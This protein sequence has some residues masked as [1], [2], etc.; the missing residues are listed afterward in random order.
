MFS[1][2]PSQSH[3]FQNMIKRFPTVRTS[4]LLLNLPTLALQRVCQLGNSWLHPW[5][6]P[7]RK[8]KLDAYVALISDLNLRYGSNIFFS[9]IT[10]FF[11]QGGSLHFSIQHPSLNWTVFWTLKFSSCL[12]GIPKQFLAQPEVM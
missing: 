9:N 11:Q 2:K 10:G 12:P 7:E 8:S 4:Q 6:H 1:S 3:S 5:L